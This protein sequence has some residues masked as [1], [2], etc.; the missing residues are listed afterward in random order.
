MIVIKEKS[1]EELIKFYER[2]LEN[3][4]IMHNPNNHESSLLKEKCQEYI[5]FAENELQEVKDDRGW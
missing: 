1:Q 2:R 4:K 3:V 5:D